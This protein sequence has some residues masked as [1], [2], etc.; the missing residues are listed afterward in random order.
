[1]VKHNN[2]QLLLVVVVA[3]LGLYWVN[4]EYGISLMKPVAVLVFLVILK[5]WLRTLS[6]FGYVLAHVLIF[7]GLYFGAKYWLEHTAIIEQ[8][9]KAADLFSVFSK[10]ATK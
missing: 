6:T 4:T 9:T 7:G 1:M 3:V 8:A 2:I 5:L 10:F